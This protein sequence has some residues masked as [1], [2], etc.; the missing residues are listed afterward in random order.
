MYGD[1]Q[2][3][4]IG[5]SRP[6]LADDRAACGERAV[7]QV[8]CGAAALGVRLADYRAARGE[9]AVVQG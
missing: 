4:I 1:T 6:G 3:A 8:W 7:V 5:F 9:R 2:Q